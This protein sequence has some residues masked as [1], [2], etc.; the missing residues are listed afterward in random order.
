MARRFKPQPP[1]K[2]SFWK[3]D[4]K[5]WYVEPTDLQAAIKN[6]GISDEVLRHRLGAGYRHLQEAL[7]GKR[8]DGWTVTHIEWGLKP[9]VHSDDYMYGVPT[10][11][12]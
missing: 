6:S 9:H 8:I 1:I 12:K 5:R 11:K 4:G 3:R 10:E 7:E 2:M